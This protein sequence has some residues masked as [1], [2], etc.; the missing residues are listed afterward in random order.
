[1]FVCSQAKSGKWFL[2]D[3]FLRHRA[4]SEKD[5]DELVT[6]SGLGYEQVRDWF[7][8]VQGRVE[9]GREPFSDEERDEE[10]R[11][12][13]QEAQEEHASSVN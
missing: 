8:E 10:E 11:E 7:R 13:E 3:Y 6:K 1:M 9:D 5:L 12:E 2:K 4:L